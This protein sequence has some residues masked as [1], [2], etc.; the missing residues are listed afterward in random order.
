MWHTDD[1]SFTEDGD[2]AVPTHLICDFPKLFP[3][4]EDDEDLEEAAQ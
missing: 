4:E 1:V 2:E 3:V